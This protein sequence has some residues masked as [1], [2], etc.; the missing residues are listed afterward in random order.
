M[1]TFEHILEPSG[2]VLNLPL[3]EIDN[4]DDLYDLHRKEVFGA[5]TECLDKLI[6]SGL[7]QYPCF[8]IGDYVFK[9]TRDS[10]FE[11]ISLC[12]SY[13]ESVEEY[14]TCSRLQKMKDRL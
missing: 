4:P 5:I 14:E 13:Y 8:A 9:L 12:Q 7:D 3:F 6:S 1:K 2:E 11:K 10:V